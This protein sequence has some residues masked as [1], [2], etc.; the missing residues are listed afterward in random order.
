M[1]IIAVLFV[2]FCFFISSCSFDPVENYATK[3]AKLTCEGQ[4]TTDMQRK[5]ALK[6]EF[7]I[8]SEEVKEKYKGDKNNA[9]AIRLGTLYFEKVKD[10]LGFIPV[11]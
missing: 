4:H 3:L 9:D 8:L 6:E 11:N 2:S 5:Q 1:K 10:C 7:R